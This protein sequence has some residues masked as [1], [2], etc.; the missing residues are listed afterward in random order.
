MSNKSIVIVILV[1]I[2]LSVFSF[3]FIKY[4]LTTELEF[5]GISFKNATYEYDG[6]IK[7]IEVEGLPEEANVVYEDNEATEIGTYYATATISKNGYK[8]LTLRATLTIKK[9]SVPVGI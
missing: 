1:L 5:E 2:S 7:K 9:S 4:N 6:T 3:C 8:T